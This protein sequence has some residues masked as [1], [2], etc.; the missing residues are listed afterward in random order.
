MSLVCLPEPETDVEPRTLFAAALLLTGALPL[1]AC[2]ALTG[3]DDLV[4]SGGAG[5]ATGAG[6]ALSGPGGGTASSAAVTGSSTGE[7]Q[8]PP[9]VAAEGVSIGQIALYQGVKR[10]LMQDGNAPLLKVPVVAG[11]PAL[12]RVFAVADATY[13]GSPVTARLDL[14]DGAPIEVQTVL[15]GTPSEGALESTINFDVPAA[16]MV[17]GMTYRVDL[18]QPPSHSKGNNPSASYPASGSSP[19]PAQST[20][21]SLRIELV[22]VSY[23]ADGSKRLPDT[24]DNQIQAYKELF[25]KL[26]PVA[27]VEITVHAPF[28][29]N[30][31]VSPNGNGW[32]QLLD[33]IANLRQNDNAPADLYYFG[34]FSPPRAWRSS[35]AAAASPASG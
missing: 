7:P 33:Q 27:G 23:G 30:S 22:P 28:A 6:G 8:P 13:D 35:A 16:A 1:T 17:P 14:G 20:G 29:W 26:Y 34:I 25:F 15:Q 24:S 19:I 32:D 12:I 9:L 31:K 10:A 5:G 11:R 2:N 3:V 4:I 18:L 21:K